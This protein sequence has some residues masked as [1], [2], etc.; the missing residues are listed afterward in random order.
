MGPKT[1][2]LIAKSIRVIS[3]VALSL[4][5][6][7]RFA[8]IAPNPNLQTNQELPWNPGFIMFEVPGDPLTFEEAVAKVPFK[9]ITPSYFPNGT[10]L[11]KV[12]VLD[13]PNDLQ[14]VVYLFYSDTPITSYT[15]NLL[16]MP[17]TAKFVI[18]INPWSRAPLSDEELDNIINS[19]DILRDVRIGGIRGYGIPFGKM[20]WLSGENVDRP[21]RVVWWMNDL[22]FEIIGIYPL[23]K[24]IR[25]AKSMITK[26]PGEIT[27][28]MVP[29]DDAHVAEGYP[30]NNFGDKTALYLQSYTNGY[31]NERI[32]LKFDL[33]GIPNGSIITQAKLYLHCWYGNYGRTDAQCYL[34]EDSWGEKTINWNNQPTQRYMEGNGN[35]IKGVLLDNVTAENL[36][37]SW[38]VTSL[39]ANKFT[40]KKVVSLCLSAASENL[41]GLY[42]FDS[43]EWWDET[44]HPYLE[45]TYRGSAS[46]L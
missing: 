7:L 41:S 21:A 1:K 2:D 37:H 22:H 11:A 27:I 30:D 35:A 24:L 45:I 18:I 13:D 9:I 38:D 34:V 40:G 16:F 17:G 10:P 39:V 20:L 42:V 25:V 4:L 26:T 31:K 44:L 32:F 28:D 23:E 6:C 8:S 5:V 33:S 14:D 3:L 43:K 19:Y 36:W 12:K 29:T 46:S 15:P